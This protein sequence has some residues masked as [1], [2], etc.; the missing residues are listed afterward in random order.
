MSYTDKCCGVCD[1][2][3]DLVDTGKTT[4]YKYIEEYAPVY[5]RFANDGHNVCQSCIDNK[6]L[7]SVKVEDLKLNKRME[8]SKN[9]TKGFS[10]FINPNTNCLWRCPNNYLDREELEAEGLKI[11]MSHKH[12]W[13]LEVTGTNIQ[14]EGLFTEGGVYSKDKRKL[15]RV[16]RQLGVKGKVELLIK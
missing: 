8:E 11:K 7:H 6:P 3:V 12:P 10:W 4:F 5:K 14:H 16:L 1:K 15:R 13:L 2:Y 9:I